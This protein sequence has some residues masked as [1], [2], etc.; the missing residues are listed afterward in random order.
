MVKRER[1][2]VID[3]NVIIEEAENFGMSVINEVKEE[4][5][6]SKTEEYPKKD[7]MEI[8]ADPELNKVVGMES[9]E[10]GIMI[11]LW[12]ILKKLEK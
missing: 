4:L 7:W 12:R 9:Y 6:M 10:K 11:L 3:P 1:E 2:K 5:G 8:R